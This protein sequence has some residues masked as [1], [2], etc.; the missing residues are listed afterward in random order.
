MKITLAAARINAGFQIKDACRFLG[1][2]PQALCQYEK[3]IRELKVSQLLILL[4]KYNVSF[5]DLR[6]ISKR[7]AYEKR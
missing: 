4:D 1:V 2:T 3:G 6:F 7:E 5:D